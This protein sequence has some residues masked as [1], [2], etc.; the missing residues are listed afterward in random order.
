MI[1]FFQQEST[2]FSNVPV[3]DQGQSVNRFAPLAR[4]SNN[5]AENLVQFRM[6]ISGNLCFVFSERAAPVV[7]RVMYSASNQCILL[8]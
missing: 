6:Q 4:F 1:S 3:C 7:D 5:D 2:N 8:V